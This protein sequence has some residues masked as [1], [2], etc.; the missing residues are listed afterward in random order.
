MIGTVAGLSALAGLALAQR[1]AL[2]LCRVADVPWSRRI[3]WVGGPWCVTPLDTRGLYQLA[4]LHYLEPARF[5]GG[6]GFPER[7]AV[8]RH[9]PIVAAVEWAPDGGGT[10]RVFLAAD[11][12][13]GAGAAE[14]RRWHEGRE[15]A[16]DEEMRRMVWE[17]VA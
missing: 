3:T 16:R 2:A 6:L 9:G 1:A 11:E 5:G 7:V 8:I 13:V 12:L 4:M 17:G 14:L 15:R 10:T